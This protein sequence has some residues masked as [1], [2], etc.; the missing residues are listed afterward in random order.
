LEDVLGWLLVEGKQDATTVDINS[1]S[2]LRQTI[3]SS[4]YRKTGSA[5]PESNWG[6]SMV[7]VIL[8]GN[9]KHFEEL[10]VLD[11]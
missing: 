9:D 3:R 2:L 11:D 1:I 10:M 6:N 5:R 7:V 4:P 8:E